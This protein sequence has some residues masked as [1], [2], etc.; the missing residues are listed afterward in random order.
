MRKYIYHIVFICNTGW[1]TCYV[2]RAKPICTLADMK[3]LNESIAKD[4][5]VK[6]VGIINFIR[7]KQ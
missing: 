4:S 7:L 5:N 2:S 6:K 3:E 1:G